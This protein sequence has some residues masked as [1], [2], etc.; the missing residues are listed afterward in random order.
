MANKKNNRTSKHVTSLMIQGSL[1]W[2]L[3]MY[4]IVYNVALAMTMVGDRMVWLLPD[5]LTG[6]SKFQF[7]EFCSAFFS[8]NRSL[9][10]AMAVFCPLLLWDMMRYSH[11]IAGPI[12]RF[13]KEMEDHINGGPLNKV[14]LRDDD[15]LKEFQDTFNRF[16]AH[17][18]Q[19]KAATASDETKSSPPKVQELCEVG[20]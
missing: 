6:S 11:R 16:V 20:V 9:F 1:M 5:M 14:K 17:I 19:Q 15:L 12:Y 8:D 18:E 4:W 7:G 2:R 13:R 10:L 3:V